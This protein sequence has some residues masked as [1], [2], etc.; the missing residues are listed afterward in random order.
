[1]IYSSLL[2]DVL[3]AIGNIEM[4]TICEIDDKENSTGKR[5]F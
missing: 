3:V 5:N 1:M 2:I 4:A